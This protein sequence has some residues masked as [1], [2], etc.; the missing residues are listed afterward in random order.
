[1]TNEPKLGWIP[2][3]K[4]NKLNEEQIITIIEDTK[5]HEYKRFIFNSMVHYQTLPEAL[6][7]KHH[8]RFDWNML[9]KEDYSQEFQDKHKEQFK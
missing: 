6:L 3:F 1:M 5:E 7:E 4:E 8:T 2:F 9:K